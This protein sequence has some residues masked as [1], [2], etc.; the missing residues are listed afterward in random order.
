MP[1]NK[2][3]LTLKS[4]VYKTCHCL[5]RIDLCWL[6]AVFLP[7]RYSKLTDVKFTKFYGGYNGRVFTLF[8]H[9]SESAYIL[10]LTVL[11]SNIFY[12]FIEK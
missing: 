2:K 7:I 5:P 12:Y 6:T 8:S 4:F 10:S 1:I 3:A 9:S 11:I